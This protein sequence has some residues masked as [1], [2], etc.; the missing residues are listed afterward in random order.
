MM[1]GF[2]FRCLNI[3]TI[4]IN[5]ESNIFFNLDSLVNVFSQLKP[6]DESS[7]RTTELLG[8]RNELSICD[9]KKQHHPTGTV[10]YICYKNEWKGLRR[11]KKKPPLRKR[12]DFVN[13][14]T[15]DIFIE[16]SRR[17]NVMIFKNGKIKLAGCKNSN[18]ALNAV[19]RIWDMLKGTNAVISVD[20]DNTTFVF[21]NEMI[22]ISFSLPFIINKIEINRIFNKTDCIS[23]YEQTSQQYVNIKMSNDNIKKKAI[24]LELTPSSRLSVIE[25]DVK[26]PMKTCFM[27]F[28]KRVIMSGVD[29]VMMESHFQ[30]FKNIL[31]ENVE[32]IKVE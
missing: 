15:L 31:D 20:K 27:V 3:S 17:I 1:N 22:N 24:K 29:Y 12:N 30:R 7:I 23:F 14:V 25:V 13:Q 2:T 11:K 28:D 5:V 16:K 19:T 21:I 32:D 6:L 9:Y 10:S 18:D 26:R 4:T 8:T